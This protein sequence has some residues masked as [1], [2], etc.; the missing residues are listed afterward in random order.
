MLKRSGSSCKAGSGHANPCNAGEFY[1]ISAVCF[2]FCSPLNLLLHLRKP[3]WRPV[4]RYQVGV[5]F[6]IVNEP[7][8]RIV[9]VQPSS[10]LKGDI[11]KKSHPRNV[12][13]NIDVCCRYPAAVPYAL[14]E[15]L[16]MKIKSATRGALQFNPLHQ[17]HCPNN[18]PP[19]YQSLFITSSNARADGLKSTAFTNSQDSSAPCSL[20]I[21]LSSHS[22]E[23]GPS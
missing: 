15:I 23:R 8:C 20:S 14:Q 4:S 10:G 22:T 11:A 2:H 18:R 5:C 19:E 13:A 17:G 6:R 21:P 16:H 9:P 12:G 1:E 3:P 7:A